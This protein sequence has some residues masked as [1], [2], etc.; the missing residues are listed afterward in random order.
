VANCPQSWIGDGTCD[1]CVMALY[2]ADGMDCAPGHIIQCGGIVT[3]SQPYSGS[4]YYYYNNAIYNEGT[5]ANGGAS[6]LE[7]QSMPAVANDG[8]CEN[9]ECGVSWIGADGMTSSS[10][11]GSVYAAV[12][13]TGLTS[14]P[15][16]GTP[17]TSYAQ[18]PGMLNCGSNGF[19]TACTNNTNNAANSCNSTSYGWTGGVCNTATGACYASNS[20]SGA[21]CGSNADC[22]S[23]TCQNGGC[24]VTTSATDCSASFPVA[25]RLC[26]TNAD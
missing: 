23:G 20:I 9:T 6:W 1:E 24:T 3:A 16:V 22:M 10:G 13:P 21:Q 11:T 8:V 15:T 4:N 17:C 12:A 25:G 5:P 7:W 2:G 14:L 18:C 19:C 26:A